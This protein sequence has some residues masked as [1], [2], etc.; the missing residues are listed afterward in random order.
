VKVIGDVTVLDGVTLTIEP[1][2]VVEFQDYYRLSI[3]GTLLAV[4]TAAERILF[5]TDEPGLFAVDASHTG[6]WNGIRFHG[7]LETNACSRLE[8][9]VVEYSKATAASG[10]AHP[11]GGG[12][13]SA[14]D[15][16]KLDIVNCI[17]RSNVGEYGGAFFFYHNANPLVAG[18]LI[19]DNHALENA[20]VAYCGYAYPG[21][22]SN[23][24][25]NNTIRNLDD[26][27]IESCAFLSFLAKPRF[28][29]C[30]VFANDP[31]YVYMHVQLWENKGFYT[32][33]CDIEDYADGGLNI[34][35]DP[36]FVAGPG[37]PAADYRLQPRSPCINRGL[38]GI[39]PAL[40]LDGLPRPVMGT[41]D[42][43]A[44]EFSGAHMLGCDVFAISETGGTVSFLLDAGRAAAGRYY[45]L[46]GSTSGS[47]PGTAL[48]GGGMVV[49]LNA[50]SFSRIVYDNVNSAVFD[51]FR[52]VLDNAGAAAA[53]LNLPPVPGAAGT[54]LHFAY[55]LLWPIDTVSNPVTIVVTP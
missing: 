6:C 22:E 20:S 17:I 37:S 28:R 33:H 10:G 47:V 3:L 25:V 29:N 14:H 51:G 18:C 26:P 38:D 49:P 54:T 48:P 16:S 31:E 53:T 15:F 7:T 55:A 2:V 27:Y 44:Y 39:A 46:L 32:E 1:G 40:D 30:I 21:F 8:Q 5:T 36:L 43:G 34:D 45:F 9:C 23:T 24:I 12:A 35:A 42:M 19:A 52:G 13:I 41:V 50:D 11:Y 4:G